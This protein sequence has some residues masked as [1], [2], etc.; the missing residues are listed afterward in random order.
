M[1]WGPDDWDAWTLS[2][3]TSRSAPRSGREVLRDFLLRVPG[4]RAMTVA[5]LGCGAGEMLPFLASEFGRVVA[6]DYAPAS[7][8]LAR[9]VC[10]GKPVH[11]RRRDLRDLTPF[12]NTFHVAVALN[13]ILGPRPEDVDRIL[14][15]IHAALRE[16]GLLAAVFPAATREPGLIPLRLAGDPAPPRPVPLHEVELQYR[17]HRAGFHAIRLR[18]LE[19]DVEACL[20]GVAVR[21]ASN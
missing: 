5:D 1:L 12:R 19:D 20:L 15:E 7:L 13:S 10:L 2:R 18:R 3:G 14:R 21:R 11:F 9:R 16:G 4:R 6:V 17:L 8:A